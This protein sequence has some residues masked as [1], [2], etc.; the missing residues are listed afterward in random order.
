MTKPKIEWR[1]AGF[2]ELRTEP[3]VVAD[4]TERAERIAAAAGPGNEVTVTEGRGRGRIR[5]SVLTATP[6]AQQAEAADLSLTK[7]IDAGR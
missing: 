2:R 3:G 7:A 4:V 5:A 1:L 6:E